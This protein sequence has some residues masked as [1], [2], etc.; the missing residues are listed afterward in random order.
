MDTQN[1]NLARKWRSKNFDQIVVQN[2]AVRILK[3]SLY[4][5]HFFP[6]YLFAG[7]R[8]CG[9]FSVCMLVGGGKTAQCQ[10]I[11]GRA[12]GGKNL[13]IGLRPR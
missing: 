13:L 2:L 9:V 10:S 5:D 1:L 6:V 11:R 4:L 3:N 7:Q 8:G 12:L